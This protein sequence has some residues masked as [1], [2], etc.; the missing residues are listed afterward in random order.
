MLNALG[1]LDV[2]GPLL[3]DL[4]LVPLLQ[5]PPPIDAP[6]GNPLVGVA[7]S[8]VGAFLTTL[9][10]GAIMVGLAEAYT[11]DR[12]TDLLES[13]LGSFVYGFGALLALI[14]VSILLVITIIGI[15]VAL[16]LLFLAWL[17]WA[18]GSAIAFLAIAERI[19]GSEDGWAKPLLVGAGLNGLLALTGI[20]GLL[21]FAIG[22]AG[23]GAIIRATLA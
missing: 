2:I 16:P 11:R 1:S 12:I 10:V 4:Q 23:F 14:L 21:S 15:F 20:G 9:V 19:V 18:V 8:A 6:T 22:A 13:P 5:N 3:T 17:V 7:G